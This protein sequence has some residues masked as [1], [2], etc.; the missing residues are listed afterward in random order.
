MKSRNTLIILFLIVFST[1]G[2][3][4]EHRIPFNNQELWLNGGNVAWV[5]FARDVGPGTTDLDDFEAMFA[6]VREHGGN[7]MRFWV[8]ITGGTTPVWSGNEVTGP[9]EGT[10]E[11]LTAILDLAE[12]YDVGMILCLWSFD[13]LRESNGATITDRAK[14]ML[15]DSTLTQIYI[16]NALIPMVEEI[17]N[18]PGLLAW[19]IFNE[20]EG[21]SNEFGW[22]FNRHTAMANIQ[23]FINQT[24]GAI[25]RTNPEALVSN[26]AWSFHSLANTSNP[27]S[28][29]Y[30]SDEELI[31]AGKDSLGTLDFYMVHYYDWAGTALSPFHTDKS[32][33]GL[34]KPLVVGEFG[35]P[36][37]ELFGLPQE[38]MYETLYERGYAGALVWQ[39]VDWYQ[40][41]GSYGPSWLRALP[42]M[43][44]MSD[45]YPGDIQILFTNPRIISFEASLD[46][47][48]AGG[49]TELSWEVT[50]S[51]SVTL[52]GVET[53]S[54]GSMIV[55]PTETTTYRL[56]AFGSEGV[57][58]TSDVE[59]E[60]LPAG[61]INRALNRPS[62]AST[63]ETCCDGDRVAGF[64]FD[65]DE[66]TRWSSAWSDGSGDTAADANTDENPDE[67]WIDVELEFAVDLGS[68]LLNWEAAY[69]SHYQ[70]QTSLDGINWN[71]VYEE[72]NADGGIDS[73]VFETKPLARFVRMQ[74]LDRATEFGHSLWE[75]EVRGAISLL[76][77]PSVSIT[78]PQNGAELEIGGSVVIQAEATDDESIN[79]VSFFVNGDSVG[80]DT[81]FPYS[82]TYQ[83]LGEGFQSFYVKTQDDDGLI[84]QSP[85]VIV[86]GSNS[87]ISRRFEAEEATLSG[88]TAVQPGLSG[89]SKG[90]G[91][92][93]EG[94]GS[95]LWEELDV[96]PGEE[97]TISVRYTLP[98]DYKENFLSVNGVR[99]DT[100]QFETP[101]DTWLDVSSTLN[102]TDP[103]ESISIDHFWGYM[104]FD[105][106]D[107][108]VKGVSV[109][110][111][112]DT[113]TPVQLHLSQNYPNPF[114][115]STE[116]N[117][118]IPEASFV[119]LNIYTIAGQKVATL[120][121]QKQSS[122]EY[123]VSWN[124]ASSS[125]GV[126]IYRLK[127]D[128]GVLSKKMV[129]IK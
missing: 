34:D 66:N 70:I 124:A 115:P 120:V 56:I 37:N 97:V 6:Q 20:P 31:A 18:H 113:E 99:V 119:E 129:L 69:S 93:M 126:Y 32:T 4:Q 105:Y 16:D 72:T 36:E 86:E 82:F 118:S 8:H 87:V 116:I 68:V 26:G 67:E 103:I 125:S 95:I 64:A 10:I 127:T 24:A 122:G 39:W 14:A 45:T 89:A 83:N 114:N 102:Y 21:M 41:R 106:I 92:Y 62:R 44:Y 48:E 75:F 110:N 112:G 7:A 46:E 63:F 77:P 80:V 49:Q 73:L 79:Y 35:V 57:N 65:G 61:L 12:A 9:G 23:R 100:L 94:S 3:T 2:F 17:G 15:E 88:A 5:D 33:W 111:E 109:S 27:N 19:E 25:H 42:Q 104:T 54:I 55:S 13:M 78:S 91:V 59:I 51:T 1:V 52:D 81:S 121:H 40:N 53:D 117:Y 96:P 43:E 30:Y 50:R 76:Q 101:V 28:K 128:Q 90:A 58:D 74:G 71:T 22:D 84:V 123:S 47:I 85:S 38:D 60:V 11:D 108:T 107:V 29:N 98:F